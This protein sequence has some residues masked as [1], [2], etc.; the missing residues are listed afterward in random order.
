M[1]D[2]RPRWDPDPRRIGIGD[3]SAM[4]PTLDALRA[5]VIE[6]GW[7]AEEPEHHL[8]SHLTAAAASTGRLRIV[9]AVSDESGRYDV[10]LAWTHDSDPDAR[11]VRPALFALVGA[12]AETATAI[13]EAPGARGRELE[14]VTGTLPPATPFASHGHTLRLRVVETDSRTSS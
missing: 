13:S 9:R 4:L 12:I 11:G 1:A 7:V 3:A 10:D 8:L 5:Q 6:A 2:R 14:V